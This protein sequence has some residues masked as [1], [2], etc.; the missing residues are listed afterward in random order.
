MSTSEWNKIAPSLE[1][2]EQVVLQMSKGLVMMDIE[3]I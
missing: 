2:K 1:I 3:T